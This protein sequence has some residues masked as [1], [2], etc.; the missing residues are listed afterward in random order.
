MK[1]SYYEM[2]MP[3]TAGILAAQ[4][5]DRI[6]VPQV[7]DE[8][9]R[10][11]LFDM[12]C[13]EI[14]ELVVAKNTKDSLDALLDIS[15]YCVDRGIRNGFGMSWSKELQDKYYGSAIKP[16]E[17][18][19]VINKLFDL[20]KKMIVAETVFEQINAVHS[21][22][23][24]CNM[25]INFCGYPMEPFMEVVTAANNRKLVDGKAILNNQGKALKPE[26]WYGPDEEL[27]KL[28]EEYKD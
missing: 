9:A 24:Y 20:A 2:V 28:I 23:S 25:Q 10:R 22:I 21:L 11:F 8:K 14:G 19:K 15:V 17:K 6:T 4:G 7:L 5:V 13:S 12:V 3:F 27:N 26:D 16:F 1:V 18:E